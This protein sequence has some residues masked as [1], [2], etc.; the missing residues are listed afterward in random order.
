ML[1]TCGKSAG[2]CFQICG[3]NLL[4][5]TIQVHDPRVTEAIQQKIPKACFY[6]I[7]IQTP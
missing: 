7:E 6:G 1:G 5:I 4:L 2:E 3:P